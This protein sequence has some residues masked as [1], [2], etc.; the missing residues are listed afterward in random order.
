MLAKIQKVKNYFAFYLIELCQ[1][2]SGEIKKLSQNFIL[3]KENISELSS[4][5]THLSSVCSFAIQTFVYA[6]NLP[7]PCSLLTSLYV[8]QPTTNNIYYLTHVLCK[9]NMNFQFIHRLKKTEREKKKNIFGKI[10]ASK[11]D[12]FDSQQIICPRSMSAQF[13]VELRCRMR[14]T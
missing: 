12:N 2:L 14:A 3:K 1:I 4:S 11:K 5:V 9:L 6:H 10:D 8:Y 7:F 13:F